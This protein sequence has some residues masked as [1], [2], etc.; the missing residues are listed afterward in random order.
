MHGY[1]IPPLT[2]VKG[3]V[4]IKITF[5]FFFIK[6][7]MNMF[8]FALA[9]GRDKIYGKSN[10]SR[11]GTSASLKI[12]KKWHVFDAGG[13]TSFALFVDSFITY[14]NKI[15]SSAIRGPSSHDNS[16]HLCKLYSTS[17]LV[18]CVP[19]LHDNSHPA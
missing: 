16:H 3:G 9:F 6:D 8:I 1:L 5:A 4:K 15:G 19:S 7:Q 13:R 18:R 10:L 17:V 11:R 2:C 14:T 12:G